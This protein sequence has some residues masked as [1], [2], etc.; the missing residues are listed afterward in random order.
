MAKLAT[1]KNPSKIKFSIQRPERARKPR[2]TDAKRGDTFL[3][4]AD[5]GRHEPA[6]CMLTEVS[7]YQALIASGATNEQHVE[8]GKLLKGVIW[9]VNLQTGRT[10]AARD[11]EIEFVTIKAEVDL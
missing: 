3:W 10:F 8:V 4:Q 7:A 1:F 6:V 11:C 2:L 9:I 5:H